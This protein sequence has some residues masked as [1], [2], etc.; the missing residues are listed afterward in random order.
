[1]NLRMIPAAS[2]PP[3]L[4]ISPQLHG[5]ASAP[6]SARTMGPPCLALVVE[7][8]PQARKYIRIT[9]KE[10]AFHVL[11]TD[12]GEEA[13]E[14]LHHRFPRV[15][16]LDI[17]LPG[18]DGFEVC[19]RMRAQREDMGIL[20]LTGRGDDAAKVSA[21]N[22]G[23]DDYLVKPFSPEVL[24]A[25]VNAVLRRCSQ[26]IRVSSTL[27]L[28]DL[29]LDTLTMRTYKDGA[30]VDLTLRELALLSAFLRH[31]GEVLTREELSEE[32]WGQNHFGST[33]AVDVYVCKLRE[34]LEKDPTHPCHFLT[35]RGVGFVCQ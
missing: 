18:I 19:S 9:L 17:G 28:G 29:R 31:P 22:L 10:A 6:W 4:R 30:E 13:M 14:I 20:I 25:R 15:V 7:D 8:D 1:M 34:K 11:E 2:D 21:L 35:E 26:Q 16:L 5:R 32:I 27:I 23:A 24:V 12:N 3:P 33:K